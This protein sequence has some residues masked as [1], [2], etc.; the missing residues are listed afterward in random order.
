MTHTKHNFILLSRVPTE[1]I[2]SRF[3]NCASFLGKNMLGYSAV[4]LWIF[5]KNHSIKEQEAGKKPP[6]LPAR[7][8]EKV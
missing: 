6:D 3:S 7:Y 8:S 2:E 1:K 5:K 4:S